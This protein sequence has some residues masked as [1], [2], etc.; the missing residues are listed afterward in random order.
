MKYRK[1]MTEYKGNGIYEIH[2]ERWYTLWAYKGEFHGNNDSP[3]NN[4]IDSNRLT[5]MGCVSVVTIPD[6]GPYKEVK[7]FREC[8]IRDLI[9]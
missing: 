8:D 9:G 1:D 6:W 5:E 3:E 7:A 2:R 4:T